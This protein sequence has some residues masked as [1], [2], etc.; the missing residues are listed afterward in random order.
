MSGEA[1]GMAA[2]AALEAAGMAAAAAPGIIANDLS[3]AVIVVTAPLPQ[4]FPNESRG[5]RET[6]GWQ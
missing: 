6:P 1:A 4:G 5:L 2:A 3:E